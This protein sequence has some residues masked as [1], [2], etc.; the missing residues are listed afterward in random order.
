M[1][2]IKILFIC[3]LNRL[4]SGST[5]G[6]MEYMNRTNMCILKTHSS[7]VMWKNFFGG[8]RGGIAY[9]VD[10]YRNKEEQGA[11]FRKPVR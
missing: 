7:A 5:I 6:E 3:L 1:N 8:G 2:A 9:C 4:R 11:Y 10:L